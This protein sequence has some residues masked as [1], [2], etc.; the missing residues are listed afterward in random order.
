M[1]RDRFFEN[2]RNFSLL[3]QPGSPRQTQQGLELISNN[4]VFPVFVQYDSCVHKGQAGFDVYAGKKQHISNT[5]SVDKKSG[6]A[7]VVQNLKAAFPDGQD[8]GFCLL[9]TDRF[10][11]SVTLAIQLLLM[12][13]YTVG[14]IMTNRIGFVASLKE[15]KKIR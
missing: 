10:Y 3:E 1:A 6:P 12:G 14:T 4:A 5:A 2:L 7:A 15:K 13:L 9:V 8:K 11:T